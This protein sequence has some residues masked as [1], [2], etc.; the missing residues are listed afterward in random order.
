MDS[1]ISSTAFRRRRLAVRHVD[2]LEAVDRKAVL[3]GHRGDL[4]R[5]PDQDRND[6]AGFRRFDRATQRSLVAG[7]D[8][9]RGRCGGPPSLGR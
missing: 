2:D 5:R 1:R 8:D 6:D 4:G 3:A 9:D 7:M